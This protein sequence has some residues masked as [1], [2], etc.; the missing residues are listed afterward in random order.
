MINMTGGKLSIFSHPGKIT[1]TGLL[2]DHFHIEVHIARANM[3]LDFVSGQYGTR[4]CLRPIWD[5][6]L[7]QANM[8]V[9]FLDVGSM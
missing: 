2:Q 6:T 5:S 4:L 3:G 1:V 9:S 7:S 8:K